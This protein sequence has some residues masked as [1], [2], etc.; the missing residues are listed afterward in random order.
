MVAGHHVDI[1]WL[2]QGATVLGRLRTIGFENKI[3]STEL[4]ASLTRFIKTCLIK[5]VLYKETHYT[6]GLH[7]C[8]CVHTSFRFKRIIF[9]KVNF[10]IKFEKL[11]LIKK[12]KTGR[13]RL[14]VEYKE[15]HR[16]T[17]VG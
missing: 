6:C 4:S 13:D 1:T 16:K 10:S 3:K 9:Y 2:Y 5:Y 15:R 12:N 8:G 17:A 11:I 14:A 7:M